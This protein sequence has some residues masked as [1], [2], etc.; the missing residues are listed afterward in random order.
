MRTTLL[1]M[2]AHQA[3]SVGSFTVP[4]GLATMLF[5]SLAS[6]HTF[7]YDPENPIVHFSIMNLYLS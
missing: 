3:V 6:K 4:G 1:L 5:W 7:H 2:E